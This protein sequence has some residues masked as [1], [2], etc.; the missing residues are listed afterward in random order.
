MKEEGAATAL[1]I[2][3]VRKGVADNLSQVKIECSAKSR[4]LTP[5]TDLPDV[6]R[7]PQGAKAGYAWI[8]D[9]LACF[10]TEIWRRYSDGAQPTT[11]RKARLKCGIEPKPAS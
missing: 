6:M 3:S 11:R 2:L 1:D 9:C 5:A 4:V 10:A 7:V 8:V